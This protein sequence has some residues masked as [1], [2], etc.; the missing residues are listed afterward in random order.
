MTSTNTATATAT[1]ATTTNT[2]NPNTTILNKS[3]RTEDKLGIKLFLG[4]TKPWSGL[5]KQRFSD[6]IV[7]EIDEEGVV[8]HLKDVTFKEEAKKEVTY[9]FAPEQE[10]EKLV[11]EAKTKEFVEFFNG[12]NKSD[13]KSSFLFEPNDS[14]E[15]R[16][17]LHK[18]IKTRYQLTTE[19]IDGKVKVWPEANTKKKGKFNERSWPEDKSKYIQFV[20][21]KENRDTMDTI[22]MISRM[23]GTSD[24]NF[25]IAG[26]KDKRGITT[27][28][29]TVYKVTPDRLANLNQRLSTQRPPIGLGE[30]KFVN[31]HIR[32]GDLMGNRFSVVIREIQDATDQDIIDSVESFKKTGFI[33]YFGLQRFGTGSIPTYEIGIAM[34]QNNWKKAV[35]LIL[36]PREGEREEA[37]K[38]R[39]YYKDTGDAKTTITM[40][41]RGL[42]AEKKL[43]IA[44][45][46]GSTNYQDAFY[47]I[48]R[49]LRMLYTHSYQSLIWNLMASQRIEM[50][51]FDKPIVG[52]LVIEEAGVDYVTEED[53]K[54]NR[55]TIHQVVLPLIGS[56][57]QLPK[58][59]IGELYIKEMEKSNINLSQFTTKNRLIDLRGGYRKLIEHASDCT[60]KIF[61]YDDFTIPLALS[62]I[63]Y[64][65]GSAEPVDVPNG[66]HKALRICFNLQSSTYATMAY[67]E[68][69]K[70]S[71]DMSSQ[72]NMIS[73]NVN[74]NNKSIIEKKRSLENET[75]DKKENTQEESN[76]E[77]P[78]KKQNINE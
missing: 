68:I 72:I 27:Q 5:L 78:L 70:T 58:N 21:C 8:T 13:A 56:N 43:L 16:T 77:Q 47:S 59:I 53:I 51:G 52:D 61:N 42:N 39:Q 20:L 75:E 76:N 49:T 71:S 36:D 25:S 37:T 7:N 3:E 57:T 62:D 4:K 65:N 9:E 6:F 32:L 28:R 73:K 55:Y 1:T 30:Y 14:K 60:Y 64:L 26:T 11:G 50:F 2:I 46:G 12:P 22:S 29:I 17:D 19:T 34:I 24:K 40:L 44:L 54:N 18:L 35:D 48:P 41:P 45:K 38:A 33:N 10:L 74:S 23:L 15:Q 66:K 31:Q 67:R 69:L 63:D